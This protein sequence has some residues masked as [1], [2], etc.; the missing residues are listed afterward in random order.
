MAGCEKGGKVREAWGWGQEGLSTNSSVINKL[1]LISSVINKTHAHIVE[2][3]LATVV[4][5]L[6]LLLFQTQAG[7]GAEVTHRDLAE[8]GNI[9][10]IHP[11]TLGFTVV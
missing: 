8:G 11:P 3:V 9:E 6:H 10:L 4:E 1:L 7:P 2:E 5:A